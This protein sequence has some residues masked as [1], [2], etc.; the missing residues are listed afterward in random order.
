MNSALEHHNI[1]TMLYY[2][3]RMFPVKTRAD[4]SLLTVL[5]YSHINTVRLRLSWMLPS[6][7][8]ATGSMFF[9]TEEE[10]RY[11]FMENSKVGMGM[12]ALLSSEFSLHVNR[13]VQFSKSQRS[14]QT[15][16]IYLM[17]PD[18]NLFRM[19]LHSRIRG[20]YFFVC[21]SVFQMVK[22]GSSSLKF[23]T[24]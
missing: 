13:D 21:S 8:I 14:Y 7:K 23:Q 4:Y 19:L 2:T 18:S 22:A 10:A 24:E 17:L 9:S 12:I 16:L 11:F 15:R 6:P 20:F 3:V 5:P 1:T